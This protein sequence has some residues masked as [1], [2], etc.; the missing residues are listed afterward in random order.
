M[1]DSFY[2]LSDP[3]VTEEQSQEFNVT[4]SD[5]D[6]DSLSIQW[7]LDDTPTTTAHFYTFVADY[8]SAGV[9]NVTVV[10]SDRLAQTSFEWGLTLRTL[11]GL[12]L[13]NRSLLKIRRQK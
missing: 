11:I 7:Y 12:Q 13:L 3:T 6:G 10:V 2:P 5:P 4:Y 8:S 1:I 9:Y